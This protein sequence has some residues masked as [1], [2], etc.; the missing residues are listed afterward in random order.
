MTRHDAAILA[1]RLV[2]IYAWLQAVEY[3][4]TGVISFFFAQSKV[5]GGTSPFAMLVYILPCVAMFAA[6]LFLWLRA[7]SLSRHFVSAHPEAIT[8]GGS[9]SAASLAFAVVGLAVFLYALPRVVS[10]CITLVRSEH[11]I[12]GDAAPEFLQH[13]PSLAGSFLQL[14]CGFLLFVRPHKLAGWWERKRDSN[15]SV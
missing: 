5:F 12:G 4:A 15:V 9:S 14:I 10:D 6:G 8:S 13:L 2:A 3:V 7:P 1:I 11:F